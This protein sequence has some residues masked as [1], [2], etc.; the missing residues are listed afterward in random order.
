MGE[1][2]PTHACPAP[3]SIADAHLNAFDVWVVPISACFQSSSFALRTCLHAIM[4]CSI[5]F[6]KG[7]VAW[8]T[9]SISH[10]DARFSAKRLLLL[11]LL[12][13]LM[14]ERFG[15]SFTSRWSALLAFS[16]ARA[17]GASL[18]ALSLPGTA[19][20]DG[21][22]PLLSEVLASTGFDEAPPVAS[23]LPPRP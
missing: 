13:L 3:L 2:R 23:R 15:R 8:M 11:L 19:N 12:L 9:N 1:V 7:V 22:Q 5:A 16:A 4:W 6:M 17:F 21:D 10:H 20:V 14:H 18:L